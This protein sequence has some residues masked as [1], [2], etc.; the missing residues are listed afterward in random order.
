MTYS[1]SDI[2]TYLSSSTYF[3]YYIQ[4][5]NLSFID[6]AL[7]AVPVI[8]VCFFYWMELKWVELRWWWWGQKRKKWKRKEKYW[9]V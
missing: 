2:F 6:T 1:I 9:N 3:T 8:A 4:F 5:H 7:I